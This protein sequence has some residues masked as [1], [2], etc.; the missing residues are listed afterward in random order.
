MRVSDAFTQRTFLRDL[1]R[2]K[3]QLNS[4]LARASSGHRVRY[5]SDDSQA[6]GELL[7]LADESLKLERHQR[8]L[9][10]QAQPWLDNTA[11]AVS[12]LEETLI[13][14]RNLAIEGASDTMQQANRD[15]IATRVLGLR[16]K[17]EGLAETRVSGRYIFS[18]TLT[19]TPPFDSNGVYQGN[20]ESIDALLDGQTE[21]LN[22]PGDEVFGE[23]GVGGPRELLRS[24][25]A[26]LRAGDLAAIQDLA[27][28]LGDAIAANSTLLARVGNRGK[29][30]DEAVARLAEQQTA[31]SLR[32]ADL[33]AT[34]MAEAL[35]DIQKF[36]TGYQATLAAGS[37][38]FGPNF[39][40]YL[41]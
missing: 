27:D 22:L 8:V 21:T 41:G 1:G 13:E 28:P 9:L 3:E 34:D 19:T 20:S 11:T 6:A 4:A 26:A 32:A 39:F 36:Q 23:E 30:L 37:R 29:A 7:R 33:G 5:A 40:D 24:L 35:S 17:L 14:A 10:S 15:A 31:A 25:E 18:G 38:L 16:K 12:S 2:I